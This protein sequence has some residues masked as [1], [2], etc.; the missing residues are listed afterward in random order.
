MM[1]DPAKVTI[2]EEF[3][4]R[5]AELDPHRARWIA[6]LYFERAVRARVINADCEQA[7]GFLALVHAAISLAESGQIP[8]FSD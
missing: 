6:N 4:L 7:Q 5:R 8:F 3:A 1:V 2:D